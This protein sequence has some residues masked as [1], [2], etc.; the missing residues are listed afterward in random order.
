MADAVDK[1]QDTRNRIVT[2]ASRGFRS[3]GYAGIGVDGIA[4]DA[5]VTSGAFYAHLGSK[6]QAFLLAL[7]LGLDEV[8]TSLPTI[9]EEHG[10]GW[11]PAFADYYLGRAH[12]ADLAGGC[13]M[14]TL[15]PEVARFDDPVRAIYEKKMATIV[16]LFAE[17]LAGGSADERRARAW[18]TLSTLIGGLTIARG[19]KSRAASESVATAVKAAAEIAAGK[20]RG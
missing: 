5:G 6:D 4:K 15:S 14:A 1:K 19:M 18:A 10:A 11:L 20:T 12:R 16:D 7:E 9:R 3:R 17:G 13:A 8:I 2:A